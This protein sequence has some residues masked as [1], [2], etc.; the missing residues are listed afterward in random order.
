M[1]DFDGN[2]IIDGNDHGHI[3]ISRTGDG[4]EK[5]NYGY[6]YKFESTGSMLSAGVSTVLGSKSARIDIFGVGSSIGCHNVGVRTEVLTLNASTVNNSN[7]IFNFDVGEG[8][9]YSG[10]RIEIEG[11]TQQNKTYVIRSIYP[12]NATVKLSEPFQGE[13]K[14]NSSQI[15]LVTGGIPR[16]TTKVI[17]KGTSEYEYD[18]FFTGSYWN[19]VPLISVSRFGDECPAN[20]SHVVGGMNRNLDVVTIQQGGGMLLSPNYVVDTVTGFDGEQKIYSIPP[21]FSVLENSLQMMRIVIKDTDN[22]QVWGHGKPSFKVSLDG[23][24]T[25][26]IAYNS[27]ESHFEELLSPLCTK[28]KTDCITISR[29]L[30]PS[31]APNGFIFNLYF[32]EIISNF[33]INAIDGACSPFS[34]PRG[35]VILLETIQE[36]SFSPT[37]GR[38]QIPLGSATNPTIASKWLRGKDNMLKLYKV[39][40]KYWDIRFDE[41]FG[42]V[43]QMK[44]AQSSLSHSTTLS[45]IDDV[46][47]G[48]YPTRTTI[49]NLMTGIPYFVRVSATNLIGTGDFSAANYAIPSGVAPVIKNP[50]VGHSLYVNEVQSISVV[51]THVNE[52]QQ[53]QTKAIAIPEIQEVTVSSLTGKAIDGGFFSLR[54]PETQVLRFESGSPITE[55]SFFLTFNYVNITK[56][57]EQSTG[58]FFYQTMKT[59][60]IPFGASSDQLRYSMGDGASQNGLD[61]DA[62]K[63]SRSGDGSYSSRFGFSYTIT[64]VGAN[65]RGN[66]QLLNT[67]LSLSGLDSFGTSTCKPFKS[68]TNDAH[69]DINTLN[70]GLAVGTD[71]PRVAININL[72]GVPIFGEYALSVTHLG[73]TTATN[74]IAWDASEDEVKSKIESLSNVDSVRVVRYGNGHLSN[75]NGGF[76]EKLDQISFY[77]GN[78][79]NVLNSANHLSA[80]KILLEG[81]RL[82]FVGQTD[83][84]N[85]YTVINVN[86]FNVTLNKSVQEK[87]EVYVVKRF[88]NF[89]YEIIF[90]GNGMHPDKNGV[91]TFTPINSFSISQGNCTAFQTLHENELK[92]YSNIP[93]WQADIFIASAYDGGSSIP[94]LPSGGTSDIIRSSLHDSL[95]PLITSVASM[96]SLETRDGSITYTLTF[97]DSD[98]DL[99]ALV[100]NQDLVMSTSDLICYTS[101]VMNGNMIGGYFYLDSSEAIPFDASASV[102]KSSIEKIR[103]MGIVDVTRSPPDGQGGYTWMITFVENNGDIPK[104]FISSSLTGKNVN[105]SVKEAVKGNQIAGTY[106]LF[107]DGEFSEKIVFNADA[108]SLKLALEKLGAFSSINVQESMK[109]NSEGG[110]TYLVTFI[111]MNLGDIELLVPV[112]DDIKGNGSAVTVREE[113]KGSLAIADSLHLSYQLPSGCSISQVGIAGCGNPVRKVVAELDLNA[114]FSGDVIV[115]TMIPDYTVQIVGVKA[116]SFKYTSYQRPGI[117]GSFR[118]SYEVWQTDDITSHATAFEVRKALENLPPIR[119]VSVERDYSSIR[120]DG[121]CIDIVIGSSTVR[122]SEYC[123][124]NFA[125]NGL[126]GN[127]LIKI[128]NNWYRVSSSY[129]GDEDVFHLSHKE[130]SL[131]L[132]YPDISIERGDL[133]IWGGSYDWLVTFHSVIGELQLLESPRH[134]LQ[135]ID[136]TLQVNLPG[137]ERCL[138]FDGL[139]G[140]TEYY[141]RIK[142][143]NDFG[144]SGY[145]QN[146]KGIPKSIPDAPSAFSLQAI[147][148]DCLEVSFSNPSHDDYYD[149]IIAYIIEWDIYNDFRSV[150]TTFRYLAIN[151]QDETPTHHMHEICNLNSTLQYFVR[152]A[153]KNTVD[154]QLI[155]TPD[156]PQENINW[157][158]VLSETPEDQVPDR[159]IMMEVTP[160]GYGGI[161]LVFKNPVRDG[162]KEITR[163]KISWYTNETHATSGHVNITNSDLQVMPPISVLYHIN[164][165]E[166]MLQS[167]TT[168]FVCVQATNDIGDSE[169]SDRMTVVTSIPPRSTI[170]SFLSSP[171]QS[172][173]PIT[174]AILSWKPIETKNKEEVEGYLVEWW[175]AESSFEIQVIKLQYS[176]PLDK[177]AFSLSFSPSP[178]LK[179]TTAMLPWNATASLVRRELINLGWDINYDMM[180]IG[181]IEV[182]RSELTDGFAWTISFVNNDINRGDQ[183]PLEFDVSNNGDS[184]IVTMSVATF[185]NGIRPAGTEE[186]QFLEVMGTGILFGFYRLKFESS[187]FTPYISANATSEE[188]KKSLEQ[189]STIKEV[190]VSQNDNIDQSIVGSSGPLIHHYEITFLS[191]VGNIGSISADWTSLETSNGDA[192]ILIFDGDNGLGPLGKKASGAIPGELPAGYQ[193]SGLLL[194]DSNSYTIEGLVTGT[195][196]FVSL[197]VKNQ[198]HGFGEH[199]I[200]TPVSITPSLQVPQPP[201]NVSLD[202]NF[203]HSDSIMVKYDS[204]SSNGGSEI[205]RYR[206]ELDPTPTFDNPIVE[207][208]ECP[209]NNKETVWKIETKSNASVIVGGSFSLQLMANGYTYDSDPI[210]YDAVA[211]MCNETGVKEN[212]NFTQ[213]SVVNG[214]SIISAS[215]NLENNLFPGDRVRFSGQN[216][217]YKDYVIETISGNSAT[218]DDSFEGITGA[219]NQTFR[220]Y[221]GRGDPTSSMIFCQYDELLCPQD[222]LKASGSMQAKL[223][224]LKPV[225]KS[226]V[227]VD[228]D[229]PSSLNEFVWRVTFLDAAFDGS[230]DYRLS[231]I[232]NMLETHDG[233]QSASVV[234]TLL[235]DGKVH[236]KCSG[237]LTVPQYGGLVKGLNYYGRVSAINSIGYSSPSEAT[238]P[239]API[240]VPGPPTAVTLDVASSTELR[241][242]F[243]SPVDNGGDAISKYEIEWSTAM[244]FDNSHSVELDFL[245]GGSPFFKIIQGLIMGQHYFVRVKACNS[246]GYGIPQSSTPTSLNPHQTPDPPM[247]V[248]LEATSDSMLTVGWSPPLTDGGDMITIYRVEWDTSPTFSSTNS[249]PHKGQI[250]VEASIHSSYT[251]NLLSHKKVYFAR[252]FALNGAGFGNFQVSSPLYISPRKQVPGKVRSLGALPG[253]HS[254]TVDIDWQLP[255]IP[256]HNIPCSGTLELPIQCPTQYGSS[257]PCTNGGDSIYEFEVEFNERE[258]FGGSDG[259]RKRVTGTLTSID[260]LTSGR[261]YYIRALARNSIGSGAF[262][263]GQVLVVAP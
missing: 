33:T 138:Y 230:S 190:I 235:T 204:P 122:C 231:N 32:N 179:K 182:S 183:V 249:S 239:Q 79:S 263:S 228:R 206:V 8:M 191:K 194:A 154:F 110:K 19:N 219:Q 166:N 135:P 23:K 253:S 7:F 197:S 143:Q 203:G 6:K 237:V 47:S 12:H 186:V 229:G 4:N 36:Q 80:N 77:I 96:Q 78:S 41:Y 223:E 142:T 104:L 220:H 245:E 106:Q 164:P 61:S 53:I 84:D 129:D 95:T 91:P 202:V 31:I 215:G 252:V 247:L 174:S 150:D 218:L 242:I 210:P 49:P 126:Q 28:G 212:L 132:V 52:I 171:L 43:P 238:N 124:C 85:F 83:L 155:D 196:Y 181:N 101:T 149:D 127:D 59:N 198:L 161:Q 86:A 82:Q 88:V 60:C 193:N 170:E 139:I 37:F 58:N 93:D 45:V 159:P 81:D 102:M 175:S 15:R 187:G 38:N 115:R 67:D 128:A 97:G 153:A 185:Q 119:T 216:T 70:E 224:E 46:I 103:G 114:D 22:T 167:W 251:I 35:E 105:I 121:A 180:I 74:C 108:D 2:G 236:P 137:C 177:A 109:I 131:L 65:V 18:V 254:G 148:S 261:P 27:T 63:V 151:D 130:N 172:L 144:W 123:N 227:L 120:V 10:S 163:Y 71:T 214:S 66:V 141:I 222:I 146:I 240:V 51:G 213:F 152:V 40:G 156:G 20:Q 117:S 118:L 3:Q 260:N 116:Q 99:P 107:Y 200:P 232:K 201:T 34:D 160:T 39:S 26:C 255:F 234:T 244:S 184:G 158:P 17:Q 13:N 111:D 69:V 55:G 208:F 125:S 62:I 64:F 162:G 205:I 14:V 157:S 72:E 50:S 9:I 189:L 209:S 243:S 16:M 165:Q 75:E 44:L 248:R 48:I 94:A 87:F 192:T 169:D 221:G 257:L 133:F 225:V 21:L 112:T 195:E 90:D 29:V 176:F 241:V 54:M 73:K 98:G 250:D 30:D 113:I 188:L 207:D 211:L 262:T 136:A 1:F 256:Y 259:G 5:S 57:I 147:S 258:D 134:D 168:Y 226:G 89:R 178:L 246:Q 68:L 76:V 11:C 56:S 199:N 173:E 24:S 42:D 217:V 100:C 140:W 145:S 25:E 92:E 233:L